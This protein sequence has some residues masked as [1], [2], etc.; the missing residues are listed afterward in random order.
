MGSG[1]AAI[2]FGPDQVKTPVSTAT[3]SSPRALLGVN[4]MTT[5]PRH[6]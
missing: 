1:M 4:L 6:L 5:L 3:Y 2:G